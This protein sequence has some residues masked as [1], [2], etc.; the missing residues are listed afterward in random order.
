[1]ACRPA[2]L[3]KEPNFWIGFIIGVIVTLLV[4]R[5]LGW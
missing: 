1:M 4:G 2:R 3:F 5:A